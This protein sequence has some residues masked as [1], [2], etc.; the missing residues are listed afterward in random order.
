MPSRSFSAN[1]YRYGFNGQEK[2]DEVAG[3]GNVN[4]AMYWEY[5][6]RLGRTWNLDPKPQMNISDYATVGNNPIWFNDPLG[7]KL[8]SGV[9]Q[10]SQNDIKSV[11]KEKYR[12]AVNIDATTGDVSLN[13]DVYK[14]D[15]KFKNKD[16]SLNQKK[17]D[18]FVKKAMKSEGVDL[19]DNLINAKDKVGNDENY[20]YASSYH[21]EGR[22]RNNP[23]QKGVFD[24][25][26]GSVL[27]VSLGQY[28]QINLSITPHS[29]DHPGDLPPAGYQGYVILAPGV[30]KQYASGDRNR[31]LI[32]VPRGEVVKHE[33][34]EIY[35]RTH[36]GKYYEE[37]H[38]S[39]LGIGTV[40]F[41]NVK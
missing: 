19:L 12:K 16:G 14:G 41:F 28:P 25:T 8:K 9:D 20:Y 40:D 7:D 6:S 36:S 27:D 38:N 23:E 18:K 2:D 22:L 26:S 32:E 4:T 29:K 13:F 17:F 21:A 1:S 37:A 39:A 34:S 3:I 24:Y 10:A 5:D 15:D 30:A 33:L 31:P 35:I 11:V